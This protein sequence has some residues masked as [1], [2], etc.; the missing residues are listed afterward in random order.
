M[1]SSE[2]G[3]QVSWLIPAALISLAGLVWVSRR[4]VRTDRTRAA[5]LLWGGWLLV[6]GL[7]FSY[8]SGIIHP[9][10]VVALAPAI[11]ALTGIGAVALWRARSSRAARLTAAAAVLVTAAWAYA[12]LDR[13]PSW[14]PWLRWVVV[15]AGLAAAAAIL[16]GPRMAAL[17]RTKRGR[18]ALAGVPVVLALVTGLTG[19]LAY[20]A[21]TT[22]TTHTGA[23]PSAGPAGG[24]LGGGGAGGG[25]GGGGPGGGGAGG[26]QAGTRP[27]GFGGTRPGGFGGGGTAGQG[28]TGT[29]GRGGAAT[30]GTGQAGAA[31]TPGSAGRTGQAGRGG[32]GGAA[33]LGG[34]TQVSSALKKLLS[35]NS[36]SYKWVAATVGSEAAAPLQLATGDAVMSIG[37]FNGTDPAPT[38][39]QF[40]QLV[41]KHEIH[42][43]I[44][45]SGQSFGGGSGSSA[46]GTWVAGH[47]KKETVGGETVYDLTQPLTQSSSS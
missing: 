17:A 47:F 44:G 41:A 38:L 9:Y 25:P 13:T 43:Y 45:R 1:F 5:A 2:F 21:D 30:G 23:I 3:G 32:F 46:I 42:Y 26:G 6:T 19:P 33:G 39:A 34:N 31:G 11:G 24:R 15:I 40:Q 12:L 37:G 18:V 4:A 10:Y 16:A 35:Q 7:V 27:G 36:S 22:A 29:A 28:G 20:S 14:L 8:M